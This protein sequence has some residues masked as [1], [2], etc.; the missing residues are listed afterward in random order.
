MRYIWIIFLVGAISSCGDF[1]DDYSQ[2]LTYARTLA[3]IE[4]VLVGS[5]YIPTESGV[6]DQDGLFMSWLH[7]MDDDVKENCINGEDRTRT[8]YREFHLWGPYPWMQENEVI[9]DPTWPD[10]Y[11]RISVTNVLLAK[12]DEVDSGTETGDRLRG[13]CH[14][15]R[16]YFYY[17]LV[18]VYAKPYSTT[19][20]TDLGVPVK[21]TEYIEDK[22]YSRNTVE[23][24]YAQIRKDLEEAVRLLKGK[25]QFTIYQADYYAA[26][27][28]LSRVA[29]YMGDFETCV[30]A[31]N[32]IMTSGEYSLLDYNTLPQVLN[33]RGT[34][35]EPVEVVYASSTETIFSQGINVFASFYVGPIRGNSYKVSDDLVAVLQKERAFGNDL[36]S[37][38]CM[39]VNT[40]TSD[41][42]KNTM[43]KRGDKLGEGVV[44]SEWLI[45]Y[46]EVLLNKAEALIALNREAEAID[47]I[48]ELRKNRIDM[49]DYAPLDVRS[50]EALM[51]LLRDERRRELCFEGHRWFDLR[52]YAVHPVYPYSKEII[53]D[54]YYYNETLGGPEYMG[55]YKLGRYEDEPAYYVLPIPEHVIEFNRGSMLDNEVRAQKTVIQ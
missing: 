46:P 18:N 6:N 52:R 13:E 53:H 11:K 7:L 55:S 24:T 1:L 9:K 33:D 2:D 28:L 49:D 47:L 20:A 34:D 39:Y 26:L 45:K 12:L 38:F 54:H 23:E 30:Q 31:A 43:M 44:S 48:E 5:G 3:D 41:T 51:E 15:L 27:A 29:L 37:I 8:R 4:E 16:A 42:E 14:F 36:R 25:E 19:A 22:Y 17:F 21:I 32:S 50:G 35:I 10:L 40:T